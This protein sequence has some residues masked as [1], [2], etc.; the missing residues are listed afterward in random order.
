[1]SG[2]IYKHLLSITEKRKAGF[3]YLVDPDKTTFEKITQVVQRVEKGGCDAIL[4]GGSLLFMNHFDG[5]IRSVKQETDLP[6]IIFPGNSRQISAEADAILFLNFISS[7]NPNYL[8]GEQVLAAPI[9]RSMQLETIS[10]GY[11]HVESGNITTVEFLSG[12]R[13]IPRNKNEIAV[14]HA[15]AAEYIGMKCVYLEA[16]SG[17]QYSVPNEM[18][19]SISELINIP[20][21]VGGGIRSPGEAREKVEAGANFVVI[22]N[23][24]EENFSVSFVQEFADAIHNE[25]N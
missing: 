10:T 1:M 14:A 17:A 13:P 24:M 7:R 18:V 15:L 4:I 11:M 25:P 3:F 8:I 5:F 22:G 16:G 21:I 20:L 2:S 6:V 9:I 19:R 23:A 12:S